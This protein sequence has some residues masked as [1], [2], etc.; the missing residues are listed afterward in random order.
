MLM[1]ENFLVAAAQ[2]LPD[3]VRSIPL[4]SFRCIQ[5]PIE[6]T[7]KAEQIKSFGEPGIRLT[8]KAVASEIH[9]DEHFGH[10]V[11]A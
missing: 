2:L 1:S 4:S 6:A 3:H 5:I 10:S 9:E 8:R 11:G 7:G